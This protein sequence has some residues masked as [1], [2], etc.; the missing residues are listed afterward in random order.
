MRQLPLVE[1]P[2]AL[3]LESHKEGPEPRIMPL[4]TALQRTGG[5]RGSDTQVSRLSVKESVLSRA[6]PR[7]SSRPEGRRKECVCP[8]IS[9]IKQFAS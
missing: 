4:E 1:F 6:V 7:D 2:L 5:E 8:T 9:V 3:G